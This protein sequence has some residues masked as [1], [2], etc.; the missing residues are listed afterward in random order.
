MKLL[1]P[2]EAAVRFRRQINEELEKEKAARREAEARCWKLEAKVEQ[3]QMEIGRLYEELE[4][5]RS[6]AALAEQ[7]MEHFRELVGSLRFRIYTLLRSTDVD[8]QIYNLPKYTMEEYA[9]DPEWLAEAKKKYC[10]EE[11]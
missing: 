11:D 8:A 5:L 6:S 1:K 3:K 9:C 10:I 2:S 7:D 4:R